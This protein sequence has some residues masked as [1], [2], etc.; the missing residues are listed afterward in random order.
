MAK[1][2]KRFLA[3]DALEADL[4]ALVAL[5]ALDDYTPN[6]P[7]VS[8]EKLNLLHARLR[9]AADK[10]VLADNAKAAAQSAHM[11]AQWDLHEAM[12]TVKAAV[13]SQYGPDSDAI[14]SL[15]LKKKSE[16]K[17]RSRKAKTNSAP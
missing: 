7:S 11:D 6:N 17:S 5:R 14:Q 2:P 16:Y 15:G 4:A 8:I 10:D 12:L 9:E 1:R 3:S 13:M